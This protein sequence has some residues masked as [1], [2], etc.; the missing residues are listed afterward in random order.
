MT[1][2]LPQAVFFDWDGTLVDSYHFL[3]NAHNFAQRELGIRECTVEEFGVYFGRPREILYKD[4]Y[5][6]RGEEAKGHFE[7]YVRQNHLKDILPLPGAA[8]ILQTLN[9]LKIPAGIV[10]NKR[11]DFIRAEIVN[12]GWDKLLVSV[13]GAA[14]AAQDKPSGAPLI[15]AIEKA[16]IPYERQNIWFVGDTETDLA[17]A[18]EVGTPCVFVESPHGESVYS[19]K[20]SPVMVVRNCLELNDFL[21]QSA[22][23]E[24]KKG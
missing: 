3:H 2:T 5:G 4:M 11:G 13:V 12:F 14:E 21:L 24:L 17:C 9:A 8:E 22:Q 1:L 20:Y 7:S 10:S 23:N 18:Q 19:E 15:M 16:N 6:E